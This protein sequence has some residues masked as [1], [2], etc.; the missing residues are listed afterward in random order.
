MG[1]VFVLSHE[2]RL[3]ARIVPDVRLKRLGLDLGSRNPEIAPDS[4][5]LER[6]GAGKLAFSDLGETVYETLWPWGV[7]DWLDRWQSVEEQWGALTA[8]VNMTL[9]ERAAM[10]YK[11]FLGGPMASPRVA[12]VRPFAE[13]FTAG[14]V[15]TAFP[16]IA[17]QLLAAITGVERTQLC[18][19][20]RLPYPVQRRRANGR[21]PECR[22]RARS[23]SAQRS[24]AKRRDRE[25]AAKPCT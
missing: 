16:I 10:S 20:C 19:D 11:L 13:R 7:I 24:K 15:Q 3:G 18:E 25:A 9:F 4:L 14:T 17:G 5:C 2:L 22:P 21:C 6:T 8:H 23:A 12:I 1:M